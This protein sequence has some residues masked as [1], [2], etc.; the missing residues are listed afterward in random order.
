M[1]RSP[2]IPVFFL[3]LPYQEEKQLS[4]DFASQTFSKDGHHD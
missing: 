4:L 3:A 1:K 2:F